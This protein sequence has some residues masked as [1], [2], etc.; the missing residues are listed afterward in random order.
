VGIVYSKQGRIAMAITVDE[1]PVSWSVD[2]PGYLMI[3]KLSLMLIDGLK[4]R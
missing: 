1:M 4:S 3:S 2:N